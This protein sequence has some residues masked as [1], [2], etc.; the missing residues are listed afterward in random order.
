M[1]LRLQKQTL[2][3]RNAAACLKVETCLGALLRERSLKQSS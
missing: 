1:K 3:K 2:T